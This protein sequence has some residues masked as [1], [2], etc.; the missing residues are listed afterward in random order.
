MPKLILREASDHD[1]YLLFKWANDKAVRKNSF[2]QEEITWSSHLK[3]FNSRIKSEKT[4]IFILTFNN[5]NAGQI[6]FDLK[7]DNYWLID[8][9]IDIDQRGK[10]YGLQIIEMGIKSFPIPAKFMAKVKLL[11]LPSIK[12]FQRLKFDEEIDNEGNYVFRLDDKEL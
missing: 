11:N 4:R 5:I 2:S 9:S 7:E 3:W 8:Y 10:G 1:A 12:I 6:R